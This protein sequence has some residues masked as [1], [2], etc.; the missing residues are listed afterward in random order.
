MVSGMAKENG[1]REKQNIQVTTLKAWKKGMENCIFRVE[2][3]TKEILS[4]IKEKATDRCFGQMDPSIR[5]IGKMEFK[6]VRD[7]YT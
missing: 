2:T 3:S 5:E 1:H 4:M 7:R 6:M